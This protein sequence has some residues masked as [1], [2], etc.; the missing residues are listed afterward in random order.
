MKASA[1]LALLFAG[2]VAKG[3]AEEVTGTILWKSRPAIFDGYHLATK[4]SLDTQD[5][6]V[7]D[8]FMLFP[9]LGEKDDPSVY[10]NVSRYLNEDYQI[11]FENEGLNSKE[12]AKDRMIAI[13]NDKGR[14]IE[15]SDMLP[16][17]V[18]KREF[19]YLYKKLNSQEQSR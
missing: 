6:L 2:N 16:L 10:S 4:Y 14:R 17:D 12:F 18:I 7:A 3:L 13:I 15:I 9:V 8:M 1:L 19:P 11:I 5:K